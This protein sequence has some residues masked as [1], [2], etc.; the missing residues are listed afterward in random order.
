MVSRSLKENSNSAFIQ[1]I[2][3]ILLS[4]NENTVRYHAVIV[5]LI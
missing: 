2:L 5:L 1:S 3:A 4:T